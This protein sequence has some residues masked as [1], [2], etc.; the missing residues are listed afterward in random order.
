MANFY[1]IAKSIWQKTFTTV[2]FEVYNLIAYYFLT[3]FAGNYLCVI[4]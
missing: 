3:T 2:T 1:S 4:L